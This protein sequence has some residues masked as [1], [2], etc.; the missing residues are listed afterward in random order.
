MVSVCLPSAALLQHLPSYL[1]FSY[2]GRGV[3][4]HGCSSKAQ[5]LLLTLDE[6]YL[7]TATIPDLQ[8]GITP[9]GP[10]VL[11]SP[12]SSGLF[13]PAAGPGLRRGWLL[14]A[15][16]PSL[17]L[18]EATQGHYPWPR[19]RGGFSRCL[20]NVHILIS[21]VQFSH[22]VVSNSLRPHESQHVRPACPSPTP[23]VHS[24]SH[25]SSQ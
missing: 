16:V 12:H 8:C 23:R 17:G 6:G 10:P 22:S 15:D 1:G 9:L 19:A 18:G 3:S 7:L 5:P 4:L 21:S 2:L 14:L 11:L 20:N 24:D 13:L 25:P